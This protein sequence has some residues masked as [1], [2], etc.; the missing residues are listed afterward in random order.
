MIAI[1]KLGSRS[2]MRGSMENCWLLIAMITKTTAVRAPKTG[3]NT[4]AAARTS[5]SMG[6]SA[7]GTTLTWAAF[8]R[9][10]KLDRPTTRRTTR[11]VKKELA[12]KPLEPLPTVKNAVSSV[13]TRATR[14]PSTRLR[15][16]VGTDSRMVP[17]SQTLLFSRRRRRMASTTMTVHGN[18]MIVM[19]RLMPKP[20][21]D[22]VAPAPVKMPIP[23]GMSMK[24]APVRI[25]AREM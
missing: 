11:K 3:R 13:V 24:D 8:W 14:T 2:S 1:A 10:V 21:V 16:A 23:T 22:I 17:S 9:A 6:A 4:R 20:L 15:S 19:P 7:R 12:R 18:A 25:P 5:V